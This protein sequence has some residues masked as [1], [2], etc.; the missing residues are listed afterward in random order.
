[1]EECVG[2]AC[3]YQ[4]TVGTKT[5]QTPREQNNVAGKITAN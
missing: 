1:M 2:I 5:F 4:F 3:Y